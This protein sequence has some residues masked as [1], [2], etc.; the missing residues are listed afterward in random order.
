MLF[1]IVDS[2]SRLAVIPRDL[3]AVEPRSRPPH[4]PEGEG[5]HS[6]LAPHSLLLLYGNG[7]LC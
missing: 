7:V 2:L 5:E 3:V 4:R 6:T 1:L